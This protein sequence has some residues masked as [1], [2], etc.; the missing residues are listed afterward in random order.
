MCWSWGAASLA[1]QRRWQPGALGATVTIVEA[2]DTLGLNR[3]VLP[4]FLSGERS[5]GELQSH[6]ALHLSREFGVELRLNER[7]LTV[8]S[9]AHT[10][11][12]LGGRLSFDSLVLAT[13]SHRFCDEIKGMSKQGVFLMRSSDDYFSLS[14]S[15]VGMS[16]LAIAGAAPLS[17]IVAQALSRNL[18]GPGLPRRGRAWTFLVWSRTHGVPGGVSAGH[19]AAELRHRFDLGDGARR[20]G[21]FCWQSLHLRWIGAAPEK[22]A[23]IAE[24]RLFHGRQRRSSRRPVDA[25][26][27]C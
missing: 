10:A 23:S 25:H 17:L 16:R 19:R 13:G 6:A 2:S 4:Q 15:I 7:V 12:T 3:A 8:D 27:L 26:I 22:L 18:E 5:R 9:S 14:K 11:T 24:H 1:W 21:D 20:G